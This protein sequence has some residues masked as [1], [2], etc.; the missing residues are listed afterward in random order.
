MF[1]SWLPRQLSRQLL[2]ATRLRRGDSPTYSFSAARRVADRARG[3][4]L[5]SRSDG[6]T[7]F[8][9]KT[10]TRGPS[11]EGGGGRLLRSLPW[12]KAPFVSPPSR[13]WYVSTTILPRALVRRI[14]ASSTSRSAPSS[15]FTATLSAMKDF[16]A[17]CRRLG[18]ARRGT[19]AAMVAASCA[20]VVMGCC[21]LAATIALAIL[22]ARRSP[23]YLQRIPDKSC[24]GN[25]FTR[26]AALVSCV[27]S[28]LMSSGP[29][30]RK[31]KPRRPVV[32]CSRDT[33]QSTRTPSTAS[34]PSSSKI[35]SNRAWLSFTR[36]IG[37]PASRVFALSIA[38]GSRSIPINRP[39]GFIRSSIAAACPPL[40]TVA[41]TNRSP[42]S[43]A[44]YSKVSST[45]TG[46][47][48][49]GSSALSPSHVSD[50]NLSGLL[51]HPFGCKLL[52]L[53]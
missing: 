4:S 46:R 18:C 6:L 9:V 40:P 27:G 21:C 23:P 50:P 47:C 48:S 26:S 45:R 49:A 39:P 43:A 19:A 12:R 5:I 16:V 52:L 1:F 11:P 15:S 32:S 20:V 13:L 36:V 38:S 8:L 34:I 31:L 42:G 22:R 14:A 35:T 29:S 33:P 2:R 30:S 10:L 44:R 41:S 25:L 24:S 7:A 53:I 17:A 51:H 3:F 28:I 37:S